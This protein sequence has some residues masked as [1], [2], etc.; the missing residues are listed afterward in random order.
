MVNTLEITHVPKELKLILELMKEGNEQYIQEHQLHLCEGIDWDLFIDLTKHHRVY[1]LLHSKVKLLEDNLVPSFVFRFLNKQYKKNTFQML[2]LTGEMEGVSKLFTENK[3]RSLF[4]KG[5]I[6]A[7]DLYGNLSLR[8][9]SDLD[10]LIPTDQLVN[11]EQILE[12]KGYVKDD[13]IRTV[14]NDW[15]W[16]HHHVT[17]IHPRTKIKVEI[18]WRIN[19]G[20]GKQPNFNELW[21]RKSRSLITSYPL[22]SLGKED[23]FVFLV[24]HG[25]RHGW[26]RLRW[27][28][29]IQH[30]T[31]LD[32]DWRM[33]RHFM[34]KYHYLKVGGQAVF[35]ARQLLNV[36]LSN[37][38]KSLISKRSRILAQQAVFY[39]ESMVSLHIVPV[40]AKVAQYHKRH[41]FSLMAKEQ[42]LLF[43]LSCLYP[44]PEDKETFPLPKQLHFLYFPLRPFL[45]AWRKTTKHAMS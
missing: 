14:L 19:P 39:L 27:L 23:L 41:L 5:P 6:L 44:Y 10:V 11:A 28:L 26:S 7:H 36:E 43:I 16:R 45:W 20:P 29:D 17:Y 22:Y 8:T 32:L 33:V 25:A 42:K 38:M 3:I 34:K 1:P 2:H 37:E 35:L 9:S 12:D 4:L 15:K 24:S 40:P 21:E 18:H 13:Y 31:K 30:I